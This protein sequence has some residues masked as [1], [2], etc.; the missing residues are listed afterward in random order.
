[1]PLM[2]DSEITF[3]DVPMPGTQPF[4]DMELLHESRK[5]YCRVFQCVHHGRR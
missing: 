3:A 4:A 1:M 5:G 2:T